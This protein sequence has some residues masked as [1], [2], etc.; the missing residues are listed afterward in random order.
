[1][2][3]IEGPL[4]TGKQPLSY[5]H[6]EGLLMTQSGPSVLFLK[7]PTQPKRGRT[8]LAGV[9]EYRFDPLSSSFREKMPS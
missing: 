3:A 1:M 6:L 2:M 5:Y 4:S 8:E 7:Y 9:G